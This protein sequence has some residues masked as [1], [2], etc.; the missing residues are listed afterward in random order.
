MHIK[1]IQF[2]YPGPLSMER[3]TLSNQIKIIALLFFA[4]L[5]PLKVFAD[6]MPFFIEGGLYHGGDGLPNSEM[7]GPGEEEVRAGGLLSL[8]VGL[9][10]PVSQGMEIIPSLGQ[11]YD[12]SFIRNYFVFD[13]K[14]RVTWSVTVLNL[15]A[16]YKTENFRYGLGF[17]YHISPTLTSKGESEE[18]K[19]Q[20]NNA[21]GTTYQIDYVLNAEATLGFRYEKIEYNATGLQSVKGDNI[22]LILRVFIH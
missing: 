13:G 19:W 12:F 2:N 22:G 6:E 15:S 3:S 1:V 20:F 17:S 5:L 10:V 8:G 16:A 7:I 11:K 4:I 18:S 21:T 9:I 14:D